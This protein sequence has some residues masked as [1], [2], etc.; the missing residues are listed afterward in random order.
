MEVDGFTW[1][2]APKTVPTSGR[3]T[4]GEERSGRR[5]VFEVVGASMFAC[6]G[7]PNPS[8]TSLEAFCG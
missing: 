8:G 2:T 3:R 4:A 7:G 5:D 6:G 1:Q